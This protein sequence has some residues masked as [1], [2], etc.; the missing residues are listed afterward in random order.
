MSTDEDDARSGESEGRGPDIQGPG[1]GSD[2]RGGSD[3]E[4]GELHGGQGEEVVS[5]EYL[6]GSAALEKRFRKIRNMRDSSRVV[7]RCVVFQVNV[8]RVAEIDAVSLENSNRA[9][10]F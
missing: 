1:L 2:G 9:P 10:F 5:P 4:C 7:G 8:V 6:Y 3:E